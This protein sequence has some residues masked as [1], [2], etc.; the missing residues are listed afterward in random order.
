M[1]TYFEKPLNAEVDSLNSKITSLETVE[2]I[3][4]K[5][6]D[7]YF[8]ESSGFKMMHIAGVVNSTG[9]V[10]IEK[11][12]P[13][14]AIFAFCSFNKVVAGSLLLVNIATGNSTSVIMS[15]SNGNLRL[16][17]EEKST[18]AGFYRLVGCGIC[19]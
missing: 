19:V 15:Q 12:V 2:H 18:S 6:N 16:I 10:Y 11:Q 8:T 17:T 5:P 3:T 7:G 9:Y 1:T 14:D 13:K 4:L